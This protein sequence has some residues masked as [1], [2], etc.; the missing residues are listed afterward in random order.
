MH[1]GKETNWIKWVAEKLGDHPTKSYKFGQMAYA[2]AFY[3]G[4][5]YMIWDERLGI[6]REVNIPR[7]CRSMLNVCRSFA[8]LY[9]SKMLKDDPV[10]RFKPYPDNTERNDE[11]IAAI[12]NGMLTYWWKSVGFGSQHLRHATQWGAI[13]GI[14]IGKMFYDKNMVSG[15]YLGDIAL[16]TVNPFHFFCNADARN[17]DEVRW[18]I[19]RFP[20]EKSVIEDR[21]DYKR[22][23]L[24]ADVKQEVEMERVQMGKS[25]D[26]YVSGEDEDTVFVYDI[27][28]KKCKD[29]PKGVHAIV[30]GG[31]N[32]VDDDNSDPDMVPFFTCPVK[33]LPDEFYGQGIL[34]NI[35]TPQRDGN[36][37]ESIVQGNASAMGNGKWMV[38]RQSNILQSALNNEES[39]VVEYDQVEPKL[40]QGVPVPEQIANRWWDLHR[41]M[42]VITGLQDNGT[43]PY[44]GSETGPGAL[45]ELKSSQEAMFAPDVAAES[46]YIEKLA[47]RFFYL[48]RRYYPEER[49]INIVGENKQP[50]V[51]KFNAQKVPRD[52]DIDTEVGAGFALSQEDRMNTMVQFAQTGIFDKIPGIDWRTIGEEIMK[53]AGLNKIKESTFQDELQARD[54]LDLVLLGEQ[55]PVSKYSNWPIHIKIFTDYT[56][57]PEYRSLDAAIRNN[58]DDYISFCITTIQQQMMEQQAA[59]QGPPQTGPGNGKPQSDTNTE[60]AQANQNMRSATGQPVKNNM[61]QADVPQS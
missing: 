34:K 17:D 24:A 47:R 18:V 36:R 57:R 53:Y 25:V 46:D 22:G 20:T 58:I 9:V 40:V 6:I 8:D 37:T 42:Q 12:G 11:D 7:E 23:E 39:E 30:A 59:Q 35:L 51:K 45:K 10:P 56:K 26:A 41:K 4:D 33:G 60:K 2:Y 50:E 3:R 19:H 5:Q 13:T 52:F 15:I 38:S 14:I 32:P 48:A 44:R 16:E 27:W 61:D 29:Y 43:I 54:N 55:A 49:Q 1:K 28:I 31:K 21:F